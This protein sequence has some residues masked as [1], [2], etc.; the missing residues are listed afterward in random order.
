MKK[1][2]TIIAIIVIPIA[3]ILIIKMI[4]AI[5]IDNLVGGGSYQ[6]KEGSIE[7]KKV[8]NIIQDIHNMGEE[9]YSQE[10]SFLLIRGKI[11]IAL[12]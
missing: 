10:L 12:I 11:W 7:Y 3:T 5:K 8:Y 2:C 4:N 9:K 1:V 6:V